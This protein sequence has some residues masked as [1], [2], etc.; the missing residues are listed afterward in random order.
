MKA[1]D[2]VF[3][4]GHSIISKL[5]RLFDEGKW[6]HVA[7]AVSETQIIEA[8]RFT[9]TKIVDMKYTD[10]EIVPMNLNPYEQGIITDSAKELEGTWYDY[11]LIAWLMLNELFRINKSPFW[12]NPNY[13][14]CS[15][16]VYLLYHQ[17]GRDYGDIYVTPNELYQIVTNS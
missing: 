5:I 4:R 1:G 7:I 13:L 11:K 8:Q 14:I 12:N 9:R 2:L 10:Y 6:T 3:V 17:I 15:E 16:L